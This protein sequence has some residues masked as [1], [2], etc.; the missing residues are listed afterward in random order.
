MAIPSLRLHRTTALLLVSLLFAPGFAQAQECPAIL[1]QDEFDGASLDLTKWSYQLGDGCSIGV[2]GW[3]NNEEQTYREQNVAVS[4]GTLKITAR[5]EQVQGKQYTSARIRTQGK[6]DWKFGRFE[7]RIKMTRGQGIWPAFWMLPTDEVYGGWP[8]SGEIDIMENVGHEPRTVHGTIHF[9]DPSPNNKMS[10][11]SYTRLESEEAFS[12]GFH[13]FAVE[14]EA[15]TIRWFVD[16]ILFA[17]KTAAD[18]SPYLWPFDE[19]F[20]FLLNLAVGGNWPG[21]P[22]ATT[23]FPQTLEVDYV[24]VYDRATPHLAGARKVANRAQGAVYSVGNAGDGSSFV[25]SVPASAAIRSGQGTNTITVDWGDE[26][27]AVSVEVSSGCGAEQLALSVQV[28]SAFA[29]DLT[30]ENFDDPANVTLNPSTTG[31]LVEVNN[32]D[33]GSALNSSAR[34]GAYTRNAALQYDVLSYDVA[35]IDDASAYKSGTKRFVID[36]FT[37]APVGSEIL[38][39]IETDAL[40]TPSNYPIGRNSR[41]RAYTTARNQWERVTLSYLDTPDPGTPD[42]G[43]DQISI[44]FAPNTYTGHVYTFD[45]FDSYVSSPPQTGLADPDDSSAGTLP[46]GRFALAS[47]YPNPFS[48]LTTLSFTLPEPAPVLLTVHDALGREV[49]RLVEGLR[50]AGLHTV[51]FDAGTLPSGVYLYRLSSGAMSTARTLM[52]AR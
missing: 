12:D 15:G 26:G 41:Y 28:E 13:E 14:R 30:F 40:T 46:S 43:I 6:G 21:S 3:G 29:R 11:A 1:W 25:W 23:V 35:V 31:T 34:S 24:R 44:L 16:D 45:H 22:D 27:G 7:A 38:L 52:L 5:K 10:G 2:C 49:R 18:T 17:S 19:R 36:L 51:P 20:H 47:N 48:G 9:G 33:P 37:N 8:R 39:Q 42:T 32:P 4:G 50:P